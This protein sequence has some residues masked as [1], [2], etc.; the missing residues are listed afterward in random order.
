[1]K[2]K[3]STLLRLLSAL[4]V[5]AM[6]APLAVMADSATVS[7]QGVL[8]TATQVPVTDGPYDMAFSI[9]DAET[10]GNEVWGPEAHNGVVVT[11]GLFSVYLGETAALGALFASFSDLYLEVSANTGSGLET[12]SPRVPLA[13]VPYAQHAASATTAASAANAANATTAAN[14]NTLGGQAPSAFAP[15]THQHAASQITSGTLAYGLMPV[16][17]TAG[18]VAIGNHTHN[19]TDF[20]RGTLGGEVANAVKTMGQASASGISLTNGSTRLTVSKTGVYY[21]SAQQLTQPTGG[22]YFRLRHNGASVVHAYSSAVGIHV[23]MHVSSVIVMNAGDYIDFYI[24]HSA[25]TVWSGDH[26]NVSMFLI[27]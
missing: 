24:E 25:G 13:S 20:F 23:D 27:K 26:S 8:R 5:L 6:L 15:A 18:T 3:V 11:N 22:F 4:A 14:A 1:M 21:V 7:Y 10:L 17:T 2:R 16:G 19:S 12:F 9:W